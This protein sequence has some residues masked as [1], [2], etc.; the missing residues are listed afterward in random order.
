MA[1]PL[2]ADPAAQNVDTSAWQ[3]GFCTYASGWFGSLEIG[4][5][6]VSDASLKFGDYRGLD[7]DGVF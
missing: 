2:Q 1:P 4:P 5:G 3:C 6:Y 7:E